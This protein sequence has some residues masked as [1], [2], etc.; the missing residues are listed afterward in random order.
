MV[1]SEKTLVPIGSILL[2]VALT[3]WITT[4]SNRGDANAKDI[5]ELTTVSDKQNTLIIEIKEKLAAIDA[6]VQEANGRLD[7]IG[8]T[9]TESHFFK[10]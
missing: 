2:V 8:K 9:I 5:G 1:I 10:R 7:R 4:I 3:S 6:K